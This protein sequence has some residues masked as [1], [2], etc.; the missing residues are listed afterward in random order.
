MLSLMYAFFCSFFSYIN[1]AFF[2]INNIC[3]SALKKTTL[4]ETAFKNHFPQKFIY[5]ITHKQYIGLFVIYIR[6]I[7]YIRE[8]NYCINEIGCCCL[9]LYKKY[10]MHALHVYIM[11]CIMVWL[12]YSHVLCSFHKQSQTH[13]YNNKN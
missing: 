12:I 5:S 11:T 8:S 9:V 2:R 13:I 3:S 4:V 1:K 6:K 10:K 7:K